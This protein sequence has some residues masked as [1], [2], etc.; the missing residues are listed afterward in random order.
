MNKF[1][2]VASD[3]HHMSLVGEWICPGGGGGEAPTMWPIP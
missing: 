3:D 2:E 1:E